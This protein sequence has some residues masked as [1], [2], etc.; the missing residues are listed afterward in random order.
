MKV[1]HVGPVT[2]SCSSYP[3]GEMLDNEYKFNTMNITSPSHWQPRFTRT[4]THS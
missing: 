4:C 3:K 2:V 1:T